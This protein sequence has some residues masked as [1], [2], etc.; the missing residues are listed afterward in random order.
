MQDI[1]VFGKG[2]YY[3]KKKFDLERE[4]HIIAFIDNSVCEENPISDKEGNMIYHPNHINELPCVP[5]VIMSIHFIE[6]W[7][8]LIMLGVDENRIILGQNRAPYLDQAESLIAEQQGKILAEREEL[9]LVHKGQRMSFFDEESY[10]LCIRK[11]SDEKYPY[12]NM[13]AQMPEKPLSR[14]FGLERGNAI[15]RVFIEMF[16]E[17]FSEYIRGNVMEIA[18]DTYTVRYGKAVKQA[19]VLHVNGW[20]KNAIKGNLATGEGIVENSVD[21]LICTQTVQFIYDI[22]NV[23]KNIYRLLK[24]GGIALVTAA[25]I[26]QLSLYDY[27]NWGEYWRFTKQSASLLFEEC[28][29]KDDI[30]VSSYGN[31]K[32]A[33]SMLYGLCVEDLKES[34]F[35][36]N[37]EQF[38]VIITIAAQKK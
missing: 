20:G 38:P 19:H 1:I 16:L 36:Y 9:V 17:K 8:Q 26:A 31:V 32:V 12:I 10:K 30:E 22:H 4:Y 25:G 27:R 37:D 35:K 13:I 29:N 11:L 21:C 14:R 23:V 6:M 28:F 2:Y 15:D 7:Q 24:K 33:T 3:E 18:D 5:I 34:D